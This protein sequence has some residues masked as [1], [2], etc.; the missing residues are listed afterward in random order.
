MSSLIA[1]GPCP[2]QAG[3]TFSFFIIR[4]HLSGSR[5]FVS[6]GGRHGQLSR[7]ISGV[8]GRL[9]LFVVRGEERRR[10]VDAGI[11]KRI[12]SPLRVH[13]L[14]QVCALDVSRRDHEPSRTP[15][16]FLLL[17]CWRSPHNAQQM[18]LRWRGT[19]EDEHQTPHRAIKS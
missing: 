2:Q 9:D 14:G 17:K 4:C 10:P 1:G 16:L 15:C 13:V 11:T 5:G 6:G 19:N 18:M 8:N 12:S 7:F 3:G